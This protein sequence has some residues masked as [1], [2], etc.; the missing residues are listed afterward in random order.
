[1][2]TTVSDTIGFPPQV[3]IK[4]VIKDHEQEKYEKMWAQPSYRDFSPGEATAMNFLK[5]ARPGK[6]DEVIDF[7]CGTGRGCA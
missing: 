7:G 1:M 4:P 2:Q 3:L 6:G 5:V